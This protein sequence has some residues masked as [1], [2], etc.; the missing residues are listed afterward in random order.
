[1]NVGVAWWIVFFVW[2]GGLEVVECESFSMSVVVY[3]N[4]CLNVSAKL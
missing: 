3:R 1:M 4:T 2:C